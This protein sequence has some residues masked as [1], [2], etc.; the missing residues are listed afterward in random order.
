M[1]SI[2]IPYNKDRGYLQDAFASV[3]R[4]T[5]RD[6]EIILEKGDYSLGKNANNGLWKARGE[7]IK[8]LAE[9]DELT[10]DCLKILV[11][12]IQGYDFIY[13]DAENFGNLPPGWDARSHDKT[14]TLESML[15]GNGIHGGSTLYRKE[16]LEAV[17]GYD[18]DLWTG[19]EYDLHLKLLKNGYKHRHVPGI[20]YRYRIHINNK[21]IP[22]TSTERKARHEYIDQIRKKYV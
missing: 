2:I 18:E 14:V 16:V 6:F 4:Q 21:S 15:K 20:V 9:D 13:S 5:Y 7:F 19:E 3:W 8:V 12:G 22:A 10:P 1:V 11:E 17:G